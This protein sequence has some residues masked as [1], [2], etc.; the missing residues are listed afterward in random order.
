M[1]FAI[2][3]ALNFVIS[4]MSVSILYQI[5]TNRSV[6]FG[7]QTVAFVVSAIRIFGTTKLRRD[8]TRDSYMDWKKRTL[9]I[10]S[11]W[12]SRH[13][14][15]RLFHKYYTHT[16]KNHFALKFKQVFWI[17]LKSFTLKMCHKIKIY[18]VYCNLS[19]IIKAQIAHVINNLFLTLLRY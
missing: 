7:R 1:P 17:P 5:S 14:A 2:L 3:S 12:L 19:K 6:I 18:S 11:S 8:T 4:N 9:F 15:I 13:H 10:D 16:S